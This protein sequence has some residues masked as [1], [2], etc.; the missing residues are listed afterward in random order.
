MR[1]FRFHPILSDFEQS[2]GGQ[3]MR[4]NE[5]EFSGQPPIDGYGAGGF[6]IGGEARLGGVLILPGSLMSWRYADPLDEACFAEALAAASEFDLLLIGM[7]AH[8]AP[9][10]PSLRASLEAS[11]VAPEPM[12]TPA[13]CRTYNVLV[14]EER[15]VA[16]ALI[17]V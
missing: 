1:Q 5:V 4:L 8:P 3:P 11:G 2:G 7:G 16:A 10:A 17:P 6:R 9:L 13:A 14:A 15:R 12:A